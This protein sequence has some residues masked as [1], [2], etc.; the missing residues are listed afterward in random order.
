M[1]KK[2][3]EK[4]NAGASGTSLLERLPV[5]LIDRHIS[6]HL[7][8][9]DLARLS[10]TSRT[11]FSLCHEP[12]AQRAVKTLLL[13]VIKGEEAEALKMINANLR[14]LFIPSQA[15][16]ID[17]SG[18][19]YKDY[20]PFQAALLS[21]D[22]TLWRKIEPYFNKL[23]NGQEEKAR[24]FKELFPE[25]LPKQKSYNFN[26]LVQVISNSSDA[27]I[28]AALRKENNDTSICEALKDF[29]T[30][31]AALAMKET[32]FNP[33][34]LITTL[35]IYDEQFTPWSWNQR[36]L[37]CNQVIGY[38]QRFLPACHAQALCQGLYSIVIDKNPL[39]RSLNLQCDAGV[40]F[41]LTDLAGLGFDFGVYSGTGARMQ[42]QHVAATRVESKL[43]RGYITQ[44][45]QNYLA[46]SNACDRLDNPSRAVTI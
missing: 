36:N 15:T 7:S 19:S 41:P 8:D 18:R 44:I 14:L 32:L 12:L 25:D 35:K 9:K 37:F 33:L 22:V 5:E 16:A 6:K 4:V 3:G 27:D 34:H 46:L 13:H 45:Q 10:R 26:T 39:R 38:I 24:Q 31:F 21:H 17:Y 28:M 1:P 11:M 23:P 42:H 40:Y 29:R 43:L 2:G 20:T 30:D